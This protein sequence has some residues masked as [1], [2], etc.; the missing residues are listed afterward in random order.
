M[1]HKPYE[2]H[3]DDATAGLINVNGALRTKGGMVGTTRDDLLFFR[4]LRLQV[5]Q[6]RLERPME[7]HA[8]VFAC[9][10]AISHNISQVPLIVRK[11]G[12]KRGEAITNTALA[13]LLADP[14]PLMSM[15]D[16]LYMVGTYLSLSGE[17]IIVKE[18]RDGRVDSLAESPA[19]L[20]PVDGKYW[21]HKV[22]PRTKLVSW[23]VLNE[24]TP[25]EVVYAP[26]EIIQIRYP[27][28]YNNYRGLAPLLAAQATIDAD[29]AMILYNQAFFQNGA[30]PGGLLMTDKPL[31]GP[32]K[33]ELVRSFEDRHR[34]VTKK[35]R[36]AVLD[37]GLKYESF[38]TTRK[39]MEFAD[40][41]KWN[42]QEIHTVFGVPPSVSGIYE[43]VN[44]ATAREESRG[45]W[46]R[47]L[48][49]TLRR[50]RG[51]LNQ[52]LFLY[53]DGGKYECDFDT[54]GVTEL[55]PDFEAAMKIG[56]DMLKAGWTAR[57]V[58]ERLQLG[59]PIN[60]WQEE[61]WEI[62]ANAVPAS[63]IY[64]V[65]Q[66]D[67]EF[68]EPPQFNSQQASF[69]Q[70]LV[71]QVKAGAVPVQSAVSIA[72]AS[73]PGMT[74]EQADGIFLP[75]APTPTAPN[76]GLPGASGGTASTPAPAPA[77]AP[78]PEG[79]DAD[80]ET[81][82]KSVV[83]PVDD[84]TRRDA[85]GQNRTSRIGGG[86]TPE[87]RGA[88]WKAMQEKHYRPEEKKFDGVVRRWLMA[89]RAEQMKRLDSAEKCVV[90][91]KIRIKA[92]AAELGRSVRDLLFDFDKWRDKLLA[93]SLPHY[94][95]VATSAA[96][97]LARE[98]GDA[99][100]WDPESRQIQSL[101]QPVAERLSGVTKTVQKTVRKAVTHAMAEGATFAEIQKT[102]RG[103]FNTSL[104]RSTTI[105]R[106]EIGSITTRA[107]F[108][109][110]R[111]A[112]VSKHEW[113]S[114]RDKNVRESHEKVDGEIVE[115]GEEF[116][117]GLRFPLD[118][119]GEAEEVINCR[120]DVAP[121]SDDADDSFYNIAQGYL[122]D[123]EGDAE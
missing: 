7:Q 44:Y 35:D 103:A 68:D 122:G 111:E 53:G 99:T 50:I 105:A 51:R 17:A 73:I 67:V 85:A 114:A 112:G 86:R 46:T 83:D 27:N 102:V 57:Q 18:G 19:E 30:D 47:K 6:T 81:A 43:D 38:K 66:G 93:A 4:A 92:D 91:G 116:S 118:P 100:Q 25:S 71:A 78:A 23:W 13:E 95:R 119:E 101:L 59:M 60:P 65:A 113:I 32:A 110:M 37:N 16:F 94:K 80:V 97:N 72:L 121:V 54:T 14:N 39:D 63:E 11:R 29:V 69:L 15:E 109:A 76:L 58:N 123:D 45:F 75:A 28:P 70:N 107:R 21:S 12:T 1:A 77:P 106:T 20:W 36:I 87:Q 108:V 64:A 89:L 5:G 9:V 117:N 104:S 52:G 8:T 31:G 22:D 26:H 48:V 24:G 115:I 82:P 79:S 120:C 90:A 84:A 3:D 61:S 62:P 55:Q 10:G 88:Y 56:G 33:N 98:I 41:R 2:S 96:A 74:P 49:P 34:G 42:R 40:A